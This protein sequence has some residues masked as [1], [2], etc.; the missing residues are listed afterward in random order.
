LLFEQENLRPGGGGFPQK[1]LSLE[2]PGEADETSIIDSY[3]AGLVC[4]RECLVYG[5][6]GASGCQAK[7]VF[8][9]ILSR[10]PVKCPS[11]VCF[12]PAALPVILT[13]AGKIPKM[14]E[15]S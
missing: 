1:K 2:A 3:S 12:E 10:W 6:W 7:A 9:C 13:E 15:E 5:L 4:G 14:T 8:Q 11:R